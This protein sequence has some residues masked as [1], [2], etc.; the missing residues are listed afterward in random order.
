MNKNVFRPRECKLKNIRN[1][2]PEKILV[3]F[4]CYFNACRDFFVSLIEKENDNK[5]YIVIQK[6]KYKFVEKFRDYVKKYLNK[7]KRKVGVWELCKTNL[8]R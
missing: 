7:I 1:L 8:S 4:S 6:I 2:L 5:N 3:M